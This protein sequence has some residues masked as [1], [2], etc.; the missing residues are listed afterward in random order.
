M[1]KVIAAFNMTLDGVCDHTTGIPDEG[2]HQHYA[3]LIDNS[4]VIL[5]GRTTYELMQFWQT[6]LQN[7]SGK[8]SMDD[9]AIS[10]DKIPKIIFSNTLKH[11]SWESSKLSDCSLIEKILELKQQSGKDILVGSRSLIIQLLNSNLIDELQI[12]IHPII[13]GK[14]LKLFDQ[15]KDRIMLKFINSK[16][17][18]S[19]ATVI[20]YIPIK[21]QTT[22]C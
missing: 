17:L 20:Y 6:L 21:D 1:K 18:N 7:P 2:L 12:C 14:G 13:E 4:G 15:I 16:T 11:T 8:K 19:G 9:F 22:N 10:I 3:D 5:Y